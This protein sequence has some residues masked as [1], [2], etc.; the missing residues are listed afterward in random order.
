MAE[1]SVTPAEWDSWRALGQM[2]RQLELALERQLQSDAQIS[3]SEYG[4]LLS[5]FEAPDRQLRAREL[6]EQ[7]AWEKSRV[8]HQVSRMEKRG[9]VERRECDTDAR[10]TWI[11]ITADGRR[12]VLRVARQHAHI[13]RA[14]YFDVL[15]PAELETI[16][17]AS[18]RVIA[19][20]TPVNCDDE[21]AR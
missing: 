2:R 17:V 6:G 11:G 3:M 10:G 8:S 1:G 20:V 18:E 15:S 5:L 12:A 19:V 4:V 21:A 13:M 7:L 14:N 16:R 9:L